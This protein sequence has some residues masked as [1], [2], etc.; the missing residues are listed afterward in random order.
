LQKALTRERLEELVADLVDR[1][2]AMCDQVLA[3][4]KVKPNDLKEMI[5]VGGMTRMP[6]IVEAVKKYFKRDPCKGVHPDEVIAL[7]AAVQ[8]HALTSEE[9]QVLLLHV[10]PQSL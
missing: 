10:T 6:K 3:E 1:C 9:T 8:A 2:I 5:L 7:G 4:A